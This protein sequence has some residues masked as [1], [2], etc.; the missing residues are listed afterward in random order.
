MEPPVVYILRKIKGQFQ[1]RETE[2]L[3]IVHDAQSTLA[4]YLNDILINFSNLR[5]QYRTITNSSNR[6]CFDSNIKNKRKIT[7]TIFTLRFTICN[8]NID[9][10][11]LPRHHMTYWNRKLFNAKTS[12]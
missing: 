4:W 9:T 7:F 12:I 11:P 10:H 8:I 1:D 3:P 6:Y 2:K 5:F